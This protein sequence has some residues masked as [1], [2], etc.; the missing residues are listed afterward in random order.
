M[1]WAKPTRKTLAS[2]TT[3]FLLHGLNPNCKNS[4]EDLFLINKFSELLLHK[5]YEQPLPLSP[6]PISSRPLHPHPF[7]Y[8]A[9]MKHF[10]DSGEANR[11]VSLF[12]EM[13][14]FRIRPDVPCYTTVADTLVVTSFP[15]AALAV[16]A[17]MIVSGVSPDTH[18]FTVLVKL[19][20]CC[21][22]RFDSAYIIIQWMF[23]CGCPPDVVTYSTL[24]AGLCRIGRVEEGL[25]VLDLMLEERRVPNVYTL[26]PIVQGYCSTGRIGEA[27]RFLRSM[28]SIGCLPNTVTYN[29]LIDALCR[30]GAFGEVEKVLGESR[31]KGWTPDEITYSVYMDGLCKRGKVRDTFKVLDVMIGKGLR[32]NAVTLNILL[33]CL[34]HGSKVLEA[35]RLLERSGELE[36]GVEV[37]NYNTVMRR[38]CDVG[39]LRAVLK[40]F[41]NMLKKGV[42]ANA[43]TFS[44]VINSL[45]RAGKLQ[46][47]KCIFNSTG[48]V[49][50]VVTYTTLIHHLYVVGKMGEAQLLFSKMKEEKV[51]PNA[52]TYGIM[53]DC[54]CKQHKFSEAVECFHHSLEDGFSAGLVGR[55]VNG[56]VRGGK[57]G[58]ALN[59][60][61]QI[62]QCGLIIDICIFRS[63]IKAFCWIGYCQRREM[64]KVC[65]VLDKM[66]TRR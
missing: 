53:I 64:Y 31:T 49:A 17:E 24:I 2:F 59:L 60:I 65:H 15:R 16:F 23:R 5:S 54:F 34:C 29:V 26:T 40:L 38:L 61:E 33:D 52:I 27:N 37:V 13:K 32:P 1:P 3:N 10:A 46:K 11:V 41:T 58:D 18:F 63:L 20:S 62:I 22:E 55:L 47:A 36:W 7:N 8:N 28:E 9:L 35:M 44:I 43:W 51:S 57:I 48:L 25:G 50:N 14:Q 56:F 42:M 19:Y 21:L 6:H 4:Q 45:C 66:L 39:Q 12:L 30:L